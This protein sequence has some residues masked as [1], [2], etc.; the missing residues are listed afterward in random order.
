[1]ADHPSKIAEPN[2]IK[3]LIVDDEPMLR[4]V[5]VEFLSM[6][7][8]ERHQTAGDGREALDVLREHPIDCMI[9]DV[10]M[11]EMELEELLGIIQRE[12]PR[13]VVVATSGYSDFDSAVHIMNQG[14]HDFLGKPLNLDSL[15][16]TMNWIL[17][18]RP[19]LE[20]AQD[21]FSAQRN[22]GQPISEEKFKAM[23]DVLRANQRAFGDLIQH[24]LRIYN[25]ACELD[26]DLSEQDC[27]RLKV[28]A[29]LHEMGSSFLMMS[30]CGE[31][32]LLE[33]D[34]LKL[35][36]SHAGIAGRLASVFLEA[37][38]FQRILCDHLDWVELIKTGKAA[39]DPN[40][41]LSSILGILNQIDACHHARPHRPA[42]SSAQTRVALMEDCNPEA[43]PLA[44]VLEQWDVIESF[45]RH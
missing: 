9:S 22:G 38:D 29:L 12:F 17:D 14:A 19:V 11:P 32:R 30:I 44:A 43:S 40:L 27:E 13:M 5:I 10:R 1:M 31:A 24:S 42:F 36:R 23:L 15:E 8:F 18:R 34:E 28:A 20:A 6:L 2:E 3:I 41:Q 33:A 21:L 7:G 4:S 39:K 16:V 25:L 45:Y 35:V 37:E 26:L